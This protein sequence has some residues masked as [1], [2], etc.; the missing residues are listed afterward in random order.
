MVEWFKC[1]LLQFQI[2]WLQVHIITHEDFSIMRVSQ[3]AATG[4]GGRGRLMH[5]PAP[6]GQ[7]S[8]CTSRCAGAYNPCLHL[9]LP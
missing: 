4:Q 3:T 9:H 1:I 5:L 2:L 8:T 7:G 6:G